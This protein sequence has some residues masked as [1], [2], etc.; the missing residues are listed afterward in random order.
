MFADLKK[1]VLRSKLSRHRN[2]YGYICP[3]DVYLKGMQRT[4]LAEMA[5]GERSIFA[6]KAAYDKCRPGS[7]AA[8][9]LILGS[10]IGELI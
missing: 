1:T 7:D 5:E 8:T 3:D 9:H 10:L 4:Y 2:E 6:G